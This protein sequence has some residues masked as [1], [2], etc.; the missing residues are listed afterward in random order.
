M[1]RDLISQVEPKMNKAVE[2]YQAD[3]SSLRTGRASASLVE[4]LSVE[5]YGQVTPLRQVASINTPDVRTIAI[6]PWDKSALPLIEKS[7]RDSQS[8]SFS[9]VNDGNTIRLSIPP[10][11]EERRREIVKQLGEKTESCYIA[12]RNVRHEALSEVRKLE[13]EKQATQDDVKWAESELNKKMDTVRAKVAQIEKDK[14]A[15]IMEI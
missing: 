10:L 3:L 15:D 12:L 8:I 5:M 2:H 9:P 1:V 7:I 11:N 13:K 4:G 14:T 6:T